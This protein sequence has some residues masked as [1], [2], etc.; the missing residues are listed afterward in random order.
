MRRYFLLLLVPVLFLSSCGGGQD[1]S[2]ELLGE[3]LLKEDSTSDGDQ[4]TISQE[5]ITDIIQ[6]IPSP[7]EI[8]A[9]LKEVGSDYDRSIL[10]DPEA[11]SRYNSNYKKALNLGIYGTDLGYTNIY[12]RNQDA[13][14]Y[15]NGVRTLADGLSIGQFFDFGTIS[16]LAAQS[17]NLDSLLL[18][19]TKNFNSINSYL[20][21]QKRSNMS[22]LLLTGGWLEALHISCQVLKQ[23]PEN[24]QLR[25]RIG[26]QKIIL[27]NIML[28]LSFYGSSDPSVNKLTTEL[29]KLKAVFD[30][31]EIERIY[32]DSE[33]EVVDGVLVIKDNSRTE[34]KITDQNIADIT[35]ITDEIRNNIIS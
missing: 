32:E 29:K 1:K 13:I 20:Q 30:Q 18:I 14:A 33:Y 11:T 31:I 34:V 23:N 26:E 25:D 8:S 12:E 15:L 3:D 5:V 9:L 7:L 35:R 17:K 16:R 27:E 19:T 24:Q 22:I 10:N 21:E 28:L 4:P 6:Q 2:K